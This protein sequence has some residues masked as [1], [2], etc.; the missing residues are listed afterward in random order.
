MNEPTPFLRWAG[1]KSAHANHHAHL[2]PSPIGAAGYREPF[3]GAG[4]LFFRVYRD[5]RPAIINDL[6]PRLIA[7]YVV[8]R[9]HVEALIVELARHHYNEAHY[10][11]IRERFNRAPFAPVVERAAWMIYLNKCGMNG[12]YRE[13]N[14][15]GFNVPFG[16][17]STGKPPKIFDA[18][19]LR[20]CSAAL[21]GVDIRCGDFAGALDDV[22]ADEVVILDP[23]YVA[24]SE[25][26]N[27]TA[28]MAGGFSGKAPPSPQR[29]LLPERVSD[30]ERLAALL[31]KLDRAGAN[32]A[33]TNAD[34]AEPRALYAGWH[35][36]TVQIQRSISAMGSVGKDGTRE[37]KREKV[38]EVIVRNRPTIYVPQVDVA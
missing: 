37:G 12:L 21:Q 32:W 19:N 18:D 17:T 1:G 3:I 34:T 31:A 15:G 24:L 14:S 7:A 22:R 16:R 20:A 10:Y 4:A 29:S 27:F 8:V 11:G 9:D 5:V 36:E 13:N 30:Q 38:G 28:Y 26:A 6:N 23:P 33:L 2:L 35:I 25:T